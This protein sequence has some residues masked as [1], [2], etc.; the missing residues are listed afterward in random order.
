VQTQ[1]IRQFA[2]E[3][4]IE[5]LSEAGKK[6]QRVLVG[7]TDNIVHD[8]AEDSEA[9]RGAPDVEARIDVRGREANL[10]EV[11]V[12]SQPE[13]AT[14]RLD[15]VAAL[16]ELQDETGGHGLTTVH[17]TLPWIHKNVFA[18]LDAEECGNNV[19]RDKAEAKDA[20]NG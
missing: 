6:K 19:K 17:E 14:G 20:C 7:G 10:A 3:R 11:G 4:G 13:V 16:V 5:A 1:D 15:A 18:E 12:H 2:L 9:S 8:D